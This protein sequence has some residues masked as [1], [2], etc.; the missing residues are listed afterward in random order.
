MTKSIAKLIVI[1][2]LMLLQETKLFMLSQS[3]KRL[4]Y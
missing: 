1:L 4:L 3:E 2:V